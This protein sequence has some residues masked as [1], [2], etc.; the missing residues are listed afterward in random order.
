MNFNTKLFMK[1][2]ERQLVQLTRRLLIK[3]LFCL[4]LLDK[5][6]RDNHEVMQIDFS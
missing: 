1:R 3:P 2:D 5:A 6:K 4:E